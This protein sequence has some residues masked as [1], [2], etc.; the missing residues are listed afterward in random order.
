MTIEEALQATLG[1]TPPAAAPAGHYRPTVRQR[2]TVFVS[3]QLPLM[4]DGSGSVQGR[5]GDALDVARGAEAA[6]LAAASVLRQLAAAVPGQPTTELRV[7]RMT[8]YVAATPEFTQHAQVADGASKLMV[9]VLG[10]HAVGT[11]VAVGVA[12]LPR[13]AAVEVD[14]LFAVQSDV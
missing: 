6:K 10:E 12:S 9:D 13:G 2:D 3:G 11:R 14:A 5:L 4:L 1:V 7:L 8:V